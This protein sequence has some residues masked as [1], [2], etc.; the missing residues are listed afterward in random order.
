MKQRNQASG[1]ELSKKFRWVHHQEIG[2]LKKPGSGLRLI[3]LSGYCA[4][5]LCSAP[6]ALT[7]VAEFFTL[8]WSK[9]CYTTRLENVRLFYG[10][11]GDLV[12]V[13]TRTLFTDLAIHGFHLCD[14]LRRGPFG[15]SSDPQAASVWGVPRP[16][17]RSVQHQKNISGNITQGIFMHFHTGP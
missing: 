6:V 4:A 15:C 16:A 3:S 9:S 12:S 17:L 13:M 2:T 11:W 8:H 14:L 5:L 1:K 10:I 7:I